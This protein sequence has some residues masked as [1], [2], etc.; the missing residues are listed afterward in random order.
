MNSE[1]VD[2]ALRESE[3][4]SLGEFPIYSRMS[5]SLA[6]GRFVR[7]LAFRPVCLRFVLAL[8]IAPGVAARCEAQSFD[9]PGFAA[10]TVTTVPPFQLVGLRF[11]PD[12]R[13]FLWQKNGIVRI[14]HD[15]HLHSTPFIDLSSQ[16]N[17]CDDRGMLGLAFD[18]GFA[19]NGY[20]YLGFV[21]EPTGNPNDEGPRTSRLIRVTA[22]PANP[23]VALPGSQVVLLETPAT[24]SS[25]TMN[26]LRFAPD[27]TLFVSN[28]DGATTAAADALS[29][30]A[31]SLDSY[32]G[33]ILRINPDG[34]A[35]APPQATNPFYDG[36]NSIRSRVW[37]YGLRNP[38][39]FDFHPILGDLY[40]GDVG[41]HTW[42]EIDRIV[43]GGNY[44]WPCFEGPLPQPEYQSAFPQCA[45]LPQSATVAPIVTY[46][47]S[48]GSAAVGGAFYTG[49]VYPSQYV[50]NFFYS[51]YSGSFIR[52]LVLNASGNV[53]QNVG[54]A[55]GVGVLTAMEVGPDGLLYFV[56]FVSGNVKR[57][58]FQ[59][60]VAQATATPTF[61]YS[62]LAVTFN[63]SGST[64][65]LGRTLTYLWIFGDGQ[66]ST[67]A[68]PAHT[69]VSSTV[70]TFNARLTVTNTVGQ[71]STA[72]VPITVGS[73]PPVPVITAPP[74]GVGVQPGAVV[75]YQ[76]SATDPDQ[77]PL[78][79]T[80]LLWTVL[81]HHNTHVHTV[82]GGTGA[83]GSF[84]AQ[85]H[86]PGN[87]SYEI[88]LTATDASGL[89]KSTSVLVP[90]LSDTIPPSPPGGLSASA[91]SSTTISLAWTASTDNGAVARYHVE[92]CA[93]PSC[94]GFAEIGTSVLTTFND[95]GLTAST[96]YT[97]RVRAED[98]GGN[99]GGY[100]ATASAT[101]GAPPPIPPGLVAA[102]SFDAGSGTVL[103]DVSGNGNNG[104]INGASWTAGHDGQAL[105]FN[106]TSNVV[107]VND[108]A[109]LDLTNGMT[110][111]AW[112]RPTSVMSGW[113]AIMQ[114][115]PDIYFLNGN[116]AANHVGIGGTFGGE[117]CTVLQSPSG[118][119][120][121]QWAHVAGTYDGTTLRL[122]VNG[123]QVSS[124]AVT[125]AVQV[126]GLPL[127]IGGNTYGSEFFPGLIDNLRIYN[128]ALSA[129][130]V[131][132]DMATP[133]GGSPPPDT[134]PA[135]LSGGTPNGVLAAGTT[136]TTLGLSTNEAATCRYSTVAGTA[137]AAMTGVFTTTGALT[138]STLVGG[139][140]NGQSYTYYVR[141]QDVAGN[142]NTN[143]FSINFSVASG[144]DTTA[145]VRSGGTPS[146][147]LAAGTTQATL[148]LSTNEAATCRYSTVAGTAYAAM[149]GV[150]TTTGAL[151][152]STL[153]GGLANGQSYT[154][155]VRCQDGAG[156]ANT[157]DFSISF[158]VAST[159]PTGL[160]A[161]YSFDA[162]SGTV[163][164]DVSGNGN[165]G[166]ING[167]SWTA[168]HDGQ[169]LSFNGTSNVVVVNDSASLDLTNGMTLEAWVRPTSVM[170]GWK[171]I[172]QKEPDIYFLNGN[173][174]ANHVGIGGTFGGECC[175]VLQSPSGLAVNQWAHVAGTYDGT[176]LR[177]YVNGTQVS[178]Q[179][180]TG[181]VQVNGL[182]LRIGGNTYG[183]E[184]FPGLIDN[185]RI[186]NRALSAA[187]VQQD[188]ATPVGGSPPPDTTPAVLSG[189]TPNGVLA[190]GT[191]QT[192][193]GLSTNEAATCR[194]STVAGTAY[195]AMT[196]VF[197]TTGALTHSTL[198]GGLANGQS[199]TYY[200]RCQDVA[201][202]ANT[203]DF[204]INFS[205]ASGADTTAPVRSGGTPSGV[206]A[207]GT[208]QATLGLS[209]NEAATCRYS[210]VAGTAY[211]AMTGVFTTTGALTHS[212]LVGGLANGQSYTYYV[213]CQDVAGNANTE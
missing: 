176:T 92:R 27:G 75:N 187:E 188:M 158:S 165:N 33:K 141:C 162:G 1:L 101:T 172:M 94:T 39:R 24:G 175:T 203:N 201:G 206:L 163:L 31:Q 36:T 53:T 91:T 139:L 69:Y 43:R 104:T 23:D 50:N 166:T 155:Y 145:P 59:G 93:G 186:Y 38:F 90:L 119:A 200:V 123:T 68:N 63:G 148:G 56:D 32:R 41:W 103:T 81:L 125:G 108:S 116:T 35:P 57:I 96:S 60:P 21:Y 99:L 124:Q 171:A 181:A 20:V 213:R 73:V 26:T 72:T 66:T 80:A 164:T 37:A 30:E 40:L 74:N 207:A 128:R 98:V 79:A 49:A 87:Y 102:Y 97:Y 143:D 134:T 113:K 209:T 29:M 76:G 8:L 42:E 78:P 62:P 211:A 111:E 129:A 161:A 110:L 86:G 183:S 154:Y 194:Y 140:A 197:T 182:P 192:T 85:E 144:A 61:G 18:P 34:S 52:R 11:A 212:T 100:S 177:L 58:V 46:D 157:N 67:Q 114:K 190:A 10:E 127:R 202:N 70:Q 204:S 25:H 28:G 16:V 152:H 132:Q 4:R 199:Y 149:T 120:V 89:K 2:P 47:R 88:V 45:Q 193:L 22:N 84:V 44:G 54:F 160:V 126:N 137:Y 178:S 168:G 106:G 189:G 174:A 5:R 159:A 210:T 17:T 167:A 121:N 64:D 13:M 179:A 122:Y 118:L 15:G 105:S 136:Q 142:A 51:D 3:G 147:V 65:G 156:N 135:V 191:T 107:V 153:V 112:V 130:E 150:F 131:Q 205:V 151:T 115:E 71:S 133:V 12:G 170:S 208:T 185:L 6:L 83:S 169:A 109:S 77:G 180:V 117:C 14:F 9:D 55:E 138:H 19:E 82:V 173:T 48:V 146:G 195:A 7:G 95:I 196:G 184:F 198:V